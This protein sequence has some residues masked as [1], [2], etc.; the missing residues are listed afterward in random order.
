MR[1]HHPLRVL[2][3]SVC[4]E[5]SEITINLFLRVFVEVFGLLP[6]VPTDVAEAL[7]HASQDSLF[8]WV[9]AVT[10]ELL[11]VVD[12]AIQHELLVGNFK[13][14]GNV[15]M[16]FTSCPVQKTSC[17]LTLELLGVVDEA[18]QHELLVGNFK[19][20]GNVNMDFTSCP[21]QKTSCVF[22]QT[23]SNV[24]SICRLQSESRHRT[25]LLVLQSEQRSVR[26]LS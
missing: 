16:D 19:N 13:N 24:A 4:Y 9:G 6:E 17:V 21:V 3:G 7:L 12:E 10:L 18:I 14:P 5:R 1:C 8:E 22:P 11:G 20:P 15:N 23:T 25:R 2:F 26:Y